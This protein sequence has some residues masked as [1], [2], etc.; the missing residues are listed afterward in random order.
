MTVQADSETATCE[1]HR[2]VAGGAILTL[3]GVPLTRILIGEC[4]LLDESRVAVFPAFADRADDLKTLHFDSLGVHPYG[5]A[6]SKEGAV[7]AFVAAIHEARV[8][9]PDD[10]CVA[11]SLW[12]ELHPLRQELIDEAFDEADTP[13]PALRLARAAAAGL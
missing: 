7:Q 12:Q 10:Y 2:L 6:F 13:A 11:W 3:P 9:D 8:E 4:R 1:L 5:V